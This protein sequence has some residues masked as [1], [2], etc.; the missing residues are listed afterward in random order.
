MR[1]R[2]LTLVLIG[3]WLAGCSSAP[4]TPLAEPRAPSRLI[5]EVPFFAQTTDQCGPAALASV[6]RFRGAETSPETLRRQIYLPERGGSLQLELI[7]ATRSHGL[8]PQR[9]PPNLDALLQEIS[10]GNPVLVLQNLAFDWLPRWHYAVVIGY[11]ADNDEI[12]LHSGER[13]QLRRPAWLF[14]RTW[15]RA[16]HWALVITRPEQP[17]ATAT[18]EQQLRT[19]LALEEV[20]QRQA[21]A[22][23]Y[24]ALTEQHPAFVHGWSAL[25]NLLVATDQPQDALSAY[26]RA[27]QLD[28]RQPLL[29]NNQAF[30]LQAISCPEQAITSL[31]CGLRLEPANRDL[32]DSLD[33]LRLSHPTQAANCPIIRCP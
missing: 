14:E 23:S 10:A 11:D 29:W 6:L 18:P 9:L 2:W 26:Q 16:E 5:G 33:E 12:I 8:L 28:S 4:P 17:A 20:G 31:H 13:A 25:A 1:Q 22:L 32:L 21:A 19:A 24:R 15:A 30:A 7:A 27:L 3:F